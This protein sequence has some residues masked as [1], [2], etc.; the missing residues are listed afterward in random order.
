MSHSCDRTLTCFRKQGMLMITWMIPMAAILITLTFIPAQTKQKSQTA[1]KKK[2]GIDWSKVSELFL[3]GDIPY[4][5]FMRV[6]SS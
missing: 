1:E 3:N 2:G 5:M 4:L 6:L